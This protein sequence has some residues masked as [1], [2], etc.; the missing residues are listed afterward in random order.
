[1]VKS[2]EG[3]KQKNKSMKELRELTAKIESISPTGKV[4][5]SFSEK[6]ISMS[7]DALNYV[8]KAL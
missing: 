6:I 8:D 5:I 2:F 1:V 3:V 7:G 4:T